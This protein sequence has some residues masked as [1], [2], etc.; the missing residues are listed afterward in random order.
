[1]AEDDLWE[2][3]EDRVGLH[4]TIEFLYVVD[5]YE[6]MLMDDDGNT[7]VARAKGD[8]LREAVEALRATGHTTHGRES[9]DVR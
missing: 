4:R 7:E 1:M 2:W 5:G 8:T 6:A 3:M 9:P